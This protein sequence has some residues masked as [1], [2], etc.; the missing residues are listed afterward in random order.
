ML[1][2]SNPTL[3][4]NAI[5]FSIVAPNTHPNTEETLSYIPAFSALTDIAPLTD[6]AIKT[7]TLHNKIAN[8]PSSTHRLI[9]NSALPSLCI[10]SADG[11]SN[12]R[13]LSPPKR[14]RVSHFI[15]SAAVHS[16]IL[17]ALLQVSHSTIKFAVTKSKQTTQPIQP[18]KSFLYQRPAKKPISTSTST[19]QPALP[20]Q[21]QQAP[22]Q[23]L[24]KKAQPIKPTKPATTLPQK[25]A[26]PKQ[27]ETQKALANNSPKKQDS[28][29]VKSTTQPAKAFSA[30]D[31]LE[32]LRGTINQNMLD[33]S[34]KQY[35]V[36]RSASK[37]HAPQIPVP[38]SKPVLSTEQK[39]QRKTS[40]YGGGRIIKNDNGTC[41]IERDQMLGS[42]V[43]ASV[44]YFSCGETQREKSFRLHMKKVQQKLHGT[45]K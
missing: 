34:F 17:Y 5:D 19:S 21:K 11:A 9:D 7:T 1:K 2:G 31:Q 45:K 10:S 16:I 39:K 13:P 37:M 26:M 42:P 14:K 32:K 38:H 29:P 24:T 36:K 35:R 30:L 41:T 25:A 44:S 28:Q 3:P 27:E 22:R 12:N 43:E 6:I 4:L 8:N 15:L 33:K 40:N 23:A 18:I 20:N